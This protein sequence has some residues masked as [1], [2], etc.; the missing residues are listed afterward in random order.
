MV[1]SESDFGCIRPF[2]ID[3][4]QLDGMSLQEAFVL[5]YELANVDHAIASGEPIEGMLIHAANTQRIGN[6]IIKQGRSYDIKWMAQ[7][8]SESWATLTVREGVK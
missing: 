5:G 3:D 8:V 6:H 7:D 4:G 1:M 2:D